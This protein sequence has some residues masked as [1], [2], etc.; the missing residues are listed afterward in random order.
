[1]YVFKSFSLNALAQAIDGLIKFF[2]IPLLLSYFGENNYGIIVTVVSIN[3]YLLILDLG[4]NS[5]AVKFYSEWFA[6][7]END[8][9]NFLLNLS[10]LFYSSIAF[11]NSLIL[12]LVG[13]YVKYFFS[14]SGPTELIL[15]QNLMYISAFVPLSNW[16]FQISNQILTSIKKIHITS[17][18]LILKSLLYLLVIYL[19]LNYSFSV[20]EY[21]IYFLLSSFLINLFQI[22]YVY[23]NCINYFR[24]NFSFKKEDVKSIINYS[25]GV[26]GLGILLSTITKTRALIISSFSLNGFIDVSYFKIVETLIALILSVGGILTTIFLPEMLEKLNLR[27][28]NYKEFNL[29][30]LSKIKTTAFISVFLCI[31]IGLNASEI[32]DLF[33]G[34]KYSFLSIWL[35]FWSFI[36]MFNIY[37]APGSS[38]LLSIGKFKYFNKYLF[39]S[40]VITPLLSIYAVQRIGFGGVIIGYGFHTFFIMLVFFIRIY[41]K[42]FQVVPSQIFIILLKY[43]LSAFII[44][45]VIYYTFDNIKINNSFLL[46]TLK[47]LSFITVYIT[48]HIKILKTNILHLFNS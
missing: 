46:I 23:F 45:F 33:V 27:K 2:T 4:M 21:F 10:L 44:S 42:E 18:F 40:C 3:A 12:F 35:T 24:F 41:K 11:L 47:T 5:G 31:P 28:E 6:N 22:I 36:L 14:S 26:L 17:F 37:N 15:F 34:E 20:L 32:L 13:F 19:T 25:M 7:G 29:Y 43:Y 39:V 9:V 48:F 1:M 8:K 30:F 16:I 38:L